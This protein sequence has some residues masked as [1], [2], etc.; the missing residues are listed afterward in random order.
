MY[1]L[2]KI[3]ASS[4]LLG[5]PDPDYF[6]AS[7]QTKLIIWA[8]VRKGCGPSRRKKEKKEKRKKKK[9]VI[10]GANET[11]IAGKRRCRSSLTFYKLFFI[12]II[13]KVGQ[14]TFA[15]STTSPSFHYSDRSNF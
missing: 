14:T 4:N 7:G 10:W 13:L 1:L 2:F 6:F 15:P 11:A 8:K 9:K 3:S 5:D 12:I